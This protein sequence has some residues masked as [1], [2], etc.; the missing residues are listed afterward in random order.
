M[1][2]KKALP[3]YEMVELVPLED[4]QIDHF[5]EWSEEDNLY[6]IIQMETGETVGWYR[7]TKRLKA[8][9]VCKYV[10]S[11]TNVV[12]YLSQN[13][14]PEE[15]KQRQ[16]S[17]GF[18]F[19][20][21][22]AHRICQEI[23]NGQSM[24]KVCSRADMPSYRY[25]SV[26]RREHPE[27]DQM[28]TEAYQDRG[29]FIRDKIYDEVESLDYK[30]TSEEISA[31]KAKIDTLKWLASKD[32]TRRYGNKTEVTG[33]AGGTVLILETGVRKEGAEGALED[34]S[35]AHIKD[36][37]ALEEGSD[38]DEGLRHSEACD[39]NDEGEQAERGCDGGGDSEPLVAP[40][41]PVGD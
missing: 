18:V 8:S 19:S 40:A 11:E 9:T 5:L 24:T 32:D 25:V 28:I 37:K 1:A 26:W 12:F 7:P 35:S 15:M 16:G 20:W 39:D 41:E 2:D 14:D 31:S 29:E 17:S 21:A 27:F 22:L 10:D 23:T 36:V 3:P 38:A 34:Y 6:R 33:N 13:I 4:L 30:A